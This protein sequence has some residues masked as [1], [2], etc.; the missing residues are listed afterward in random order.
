MPVR[1]R[2]EEL[3]DDVLI[4]PPRILSVLDLTQKYSSRSPRANRG[5]TDVSHLGG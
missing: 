4:H 3:A 2:D 1:T 5:P